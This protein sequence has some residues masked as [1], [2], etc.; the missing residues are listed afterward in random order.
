MPKRYIYKFQIKLSNS[1]FNKEIWTKQ[2]RFILTEKSSFSLLL[3]VFDKWSIK[4]KS[5]GKS[6]MQFDFF[7]EWEQQNS[8]MLKK[9]KGKRN[10]YNLPP[11]SLVCLKLLFLLGKEQGREKFHMQI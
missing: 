11:P 3:K 5:G 6:T 9:E 10:F 1:E 4:K 8:K 2:K 7:Q